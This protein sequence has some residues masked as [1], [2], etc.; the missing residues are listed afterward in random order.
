MKISWKLAALAAV[1]S[2]IVTNASV[3]QQPIAASP[4]NDANKQ[5]T[6]TNPQP[7]LSEQQHV[8]CERAGMGELYVLSDADLGKHVVAVRGKGVYIDERLVYNCGGSIHISEPLKKL[9][10]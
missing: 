5:T 9:G 7:S 6:N 8:I 10:M 4:S 1:S 2:L 3:A